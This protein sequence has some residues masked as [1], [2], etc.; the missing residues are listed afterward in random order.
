MSTRFTPLL[1]ATALAFSL[2]AQASAQKSTTRGLHVGLALEGGSLSVDG[3][4]AADEGGAGFRIGY[5][6]N[7][8][9]TLFLDLSGSA[10]DLR[11]PAPLSGSW[12]LGYADLGLRVHLADSRR[13]LVP[14]A[15]GAVGT[16]GVAADL[17]SGS[18]PQRVNFNGGTLSVGAGLNVY[19]SEYWALDANLRW[20]KGSFSDV[21][22][23]GTPV[24]G[25][26]VSADSARLKLGVLWWL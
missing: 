26:V 14:Y 16:R 18:G 22:V 3:Q 19:V 7:R 13:R 4:A 11:N 25:S 20:S 21:T 1:A 15:E 5:G 24:A 12:E 6:L 17:D 2:S 9:V 23:G 8:V 10:V